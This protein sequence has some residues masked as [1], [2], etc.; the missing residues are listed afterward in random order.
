M[1]ELSLSRWQHSLHE[2]AHLCLLQIGMLFFHINVDM[3]D[4]CHSNIDSD[5]V[6][7]CTSHA[8]KCVAM[9]MS[10]NV[11]KPQK[12]T[13]CKRSCHVPHAYCCHAWKPQLASL[14]G[15]VNYVARVKCVQGI[16]FMPA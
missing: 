11:L 15:R 4:V 2:A 3:Y 6:V 12:V 8:I 10:K 13:L 7:S 9:E 1:F 14:I 5:L 16:L